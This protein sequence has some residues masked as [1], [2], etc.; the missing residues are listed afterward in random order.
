MDTY[1]KL[2][3]SFKI[4]SFTIKS[5][6]HD[7]FSKVVVFNE[8]VEFSFLT[9]REEIKERDMVLDV[10]YIKSVLSRPIRSFTRIKQSQI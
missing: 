6:F 7:K 10:D 5:M 4:V 2:L 8:K 1:F 3:G 9:F